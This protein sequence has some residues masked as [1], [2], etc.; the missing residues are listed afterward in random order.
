MTEPT[1]SGPDTSYVAGSD[2]ALA[3]ELRAAIAPNLSLV[4]RLGAGGMGSVYLA[5]DNSLKRLVA[6]KV[7][8]YELSRDPVARGRFEREAEAVAAIAHPNVVAVYSVGELPSGIP[9]FI[10][11]Y[12]SGRSA[13]DR[14]QEDGPFDEDT[15]K[16]ILGE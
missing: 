3:E 4:R 5:R 14:V 16:R 12:V 9:Y 1:T 2:A 15:T 11:Q 10:M 8:S 6:I 7:L 13:A